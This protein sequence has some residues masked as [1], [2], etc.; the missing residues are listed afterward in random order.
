[1]IDGWEYDGEPTDVGLIREP[2][3]STGIRAVTATVHLSR[4]VAKGQA[5]LAASADVAVADA[6]R[7]AGLG[8][9]VFDSAD[10]TDDPQTRIGGMLAELAGVEMDGLTGGAWDV[11]ATVR[12][13]AIVRA[14]RGAVL[15]GREP[16][17]AAVEALS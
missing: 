6:L 16:I 2:R 9:E 3:E 12:L 1:M 4:T 17:G 5:E 14:E 15:A 11:S 13:S 7:A 8:A 10:V